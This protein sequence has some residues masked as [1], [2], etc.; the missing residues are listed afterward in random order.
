MT[1]PNDSRITAVLDW[2]AQQRDFKRDGTLRDIY[3]HETTLADWSSVVRLLVAEH[4]AQLARGGLAMPA[5]A[6]L[7]DVFTSE[8]RW[9]LGFSIGRIEVDCHFFTPDEIELSFDPDSVTEPGLPGLLG[10]LVDLGEITR[11]AVILT[12]ENLIQTV[13]FSYQ[14]ADRQ[15]VWLPR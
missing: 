13:F 3:I 2:S 7:G 8:I 12:Y 5:P 11:K 9:W 4:G 15:L 10:L 6:D 1:D 14:P